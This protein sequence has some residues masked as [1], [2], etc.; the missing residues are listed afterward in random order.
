MQ[1]WLEAHAALLTK[2]AEVWAKGVTIKLEKS[3]KLKQFLVG[4]IRILYLG[5][6]YRG[7]G[8]GGV[9]NDLQTSGLPDLMGASFLRKKTKGG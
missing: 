7:E 2:V 1:C 5:F 6:K 9:Q 4:K 8:E 3:V